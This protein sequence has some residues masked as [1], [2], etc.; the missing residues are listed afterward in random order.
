M[1]KQT[2]RV[3]GMECPNCAMKLEGME[4]RLQGVKFVE[5][6]YRKGQMVVEF[7]ETLV[8]AEQIAAEAARLGYPSTV[9]N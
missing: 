3:E 6:S 9:L 8:T 2:F 4:D 1:K 5:A 7:D